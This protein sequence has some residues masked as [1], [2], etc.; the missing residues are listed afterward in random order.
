MDQS[1][2]ELQLALLRVLWS[3]GEATVGEVQEA[4]LPE[5]ELAATTVATLLSRLSKRGV[6]RFRTQGRQ[7]IYRAAVTEAEVRQTMA[8]E[9]A[10]MFEGDVASLV[11]HL[12]NARDVDPSDLERVKRLI[13]AKEA[14]LREVRDDG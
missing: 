13:E 5:R 1:L 6:V 4:L 14:D 2:T 12:L 8:D 10:E 3:R 7:Y 11:S 9:L